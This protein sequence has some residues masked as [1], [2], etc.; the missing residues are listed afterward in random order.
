MMALT[1]QELDQLIYLAYVL[2]GSDPETN[3]HF[4]TVRA[5][6][7]TRRSVTSCPCSPN[8]ILATKGFA[9]SSNH[10]REGSYWK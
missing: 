6:R 4:Y 10:L 5:A 8:G 9:S 7:S 2:R 3:Q 1:A